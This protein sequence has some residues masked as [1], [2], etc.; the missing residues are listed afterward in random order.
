MTPSTTRDTALTIRAL[1]T[2]AT[3]AGVFS[4]CNIYSGLKIGWGFNM[5][6]PSALVGFAFWNSLAA[7]G[8]VRRM[9]LHENMINQTG[10]SAGA[11]ISS[12]GLVSAVPALTYLTGT[13]LDWAPLSIFIL[14]VSWVGVIVGIGVRRSMIIEQ[15]LPFPSG[16]AVAETMREVYARGEEAMAKVKMLASG[17]A[18]A[19]VGTVLKEFGF[20]SKVTLPGALSIG[21][22]RM[23]TLK[24]L[25]LSL[26]PSFL[27]TSLGLIVGPRIGA[28]MLIGALVGF[29]SLAPMAMT[30][31]WVEPG[32]PDGMWFGN[33]NKWLLWPGVTMMVVASLT[34]FAFALPSL[35]RGAFGSKDR[36]GEDPDD[37]P[38]RVYVML[39]A[40]I[41]VATTVLQYILFS[42]DLW[43]GAFAVMLTF[44]L[45]VVAGRVS[46]ETGITPVGPMGK[47]TQL[48]FGAVSP[49]DVTANL[50]AANVTGGAASQVGDML[51]DLKAGHIL[52]SK[53]KSQMIAQATGLL[54]GASLGSAAYL[55]ILHDPKT[56]LFTEDFPAPAAAQWR[57]VAELLTKGLGE[58]PPGATSFA[59]SA[60][61]IAAALAV[62]EKVAPARV[63]AW[64]PSAPSIGLAFVIPGYYGIA[65]FIGSMLQVAIR[66][67][68]PQWH[69]RFTIVLASGLIAGE[70]LTGICVATWKLLP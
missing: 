43:V 47:V 22:G 57:A 26:D 5:S 4:L 29:G 51:H 15:E 35:I 18:V 53:P 8:R 12:A 6:I 49:G 30:E 32:E 3:L 62:A 59:L 19:S 56:Q 54:G 13:T 48:I 33:I 25:S 14:T 66:R 10:A 34:S 67:I 9:G 40:V 36:D 23:A 64:V 44:L 55:A 69:T 52:G 7:T 17:A 39:L 16:V 50:M 65:V 20:I 11:N 61:I 24:N 2:G 45:A 27:L 63:R 42:I 70:S 31:G 28:S 37:V 38:R 60:A 1:L 68:A 21:A 58:L 46:G 41:L